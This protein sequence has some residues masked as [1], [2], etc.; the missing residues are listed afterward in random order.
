MSADPDIIVCES[1]ATFADLVG[2]ESLG[3]LAAIK[4]G[5]AHIAPLGPVVWSMGS[6]EAL[7]ML[8]WAANTINPELFD[9]DVDAITR[10][11]FAT[12]YGYEL[13]DEQLAGIFDQQ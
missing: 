11:Y 8:Y 2:N 6:T 13:S 10:E 5:T 3:E 1:P 9:Y 4:N 7:L 12:F